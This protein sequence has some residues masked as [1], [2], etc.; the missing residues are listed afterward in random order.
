M[1]SGSRSF[2]LASRLLPAR[3]RAPA[4]ALY[5]FCRAADD[6]V[7]QGGRAGAVEVLNARLDSVYAG[8]PSGPVDRALAVAVAAHALPRDLLDQLLEGFVWDV[9]GRRYE[10][11]D[12]VIDYAMRVAGSVGVMMALIMG[13]RAPVA[14]AAAADLGCAMQLTNIARDVG[15]D[16]RLGRLYLPLGWLREAGIEP[17]AWLEAP[18]FEPAVGAVVERLLDEA[19]RLYARAEPGIGFL[20]RRCR[21]S[22]RA[23]AGLYEAIGTEIARGG[24]DSVGSR[25]MV[26]ARRKL[27]V[28]ARSLVSGRQSVWERLDD[29]IGWVVL[30]FARLEGEAET[31]GIRNGSMSCV[32]SDENRSRS[33]LSCMASARLPSRTVASVERA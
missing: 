5:A 25:A 16:A 8:T 22:I 23:A 27:V 11:L 24:Y 13:V 12:G 4:T 17:D 20:P 18:S 31:R 26:P 9:E 32:G 30:L 10:T 2:F 14:L 33:T 21:L 1:R 29:R 7:D 28:L 19:E 6:A 3:V 15:E